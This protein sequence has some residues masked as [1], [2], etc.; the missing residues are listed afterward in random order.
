MRKKL[1]SVVD[2]RFKDTW[3]VG[4]LRSDILVSLDKSWLPLSEN[5][6]QHP[7]RKRTIQPGDVFEDTALSLGLKFSN[8][9][10]VCR[11]SALHFFV[12]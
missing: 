11:V 8:S 1:I 3:K 5:P 9:K 12:K 10:P 2:Y 4:E 6:D 7:Q